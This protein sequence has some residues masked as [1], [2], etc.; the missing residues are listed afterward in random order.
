MLNSEKH[1]ALV[2]TVLNSEKHVAHVQTVI[3][4]EKLAT[5]VLTAAKRYTTSLTPSRRLMRFLC[6]MTITMVKK[7]G[8]FEKKPHC[9]DP[10]NCSVCC[11][12]DLL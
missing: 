4:S 11:M 10:S 3:N 2:L 6:K 1:V 8:P 5:L 12:Y 7:I 9:P